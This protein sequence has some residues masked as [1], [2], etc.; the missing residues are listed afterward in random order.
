[1]LQLA[2]QSLENGPLTPCIMEPLSPI[3]HSAGLRILR[4]SYN[5]GLHICTDVIKDGST[6]TQ[7]TNIFS[8][9]ENRKSVEQYISRLQKL[10]VGRVLLSKSWW[11]PRLW[12][13]NIRSWEGQYT[14]SWPVYTR[15]I[16]YIVYVICFVYTSYTTYTSYTIYT[17]YKRYNMGRP[18]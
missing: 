15:C 12:G 5:L 3:Y 10:L 13:A 18:I 16:I 9:W 14:V 17:K 8:K 11:F 2:E 1:M 7:F 6:L 4:T